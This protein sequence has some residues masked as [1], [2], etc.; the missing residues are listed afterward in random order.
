[1]AA[2]VNTYNTPATSWTMNHPWA[3]V[4]PAVIAVDTAGATWLVAPDYSID[5]QVTITFGTPVA[6]TL[7]LIGDHIGTA[8]PAPVLPAPVP[9]ACRPP[10]ENAV[11][12]GIAKPAP[13]DEYGDPAGAGDLLW[14]GT[15]AG[16]LKQSAGTVVSGGQQVTV[17]Q[18]LF[19]IR[20]L[21]GVPVIE[22][23]GARWAG[24]TVTLDD[25]RGGT[26]VRRQFTVRHM[27]HAAAGTSVDNLRLELS[28]ETSV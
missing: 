1:M 15:A 18:S 9:S 27:T 23:P 26:P 17:N 16:Y 4:R 24:S 25:M 3:G 8:G 20:D 22:T 19:W 13:V 28:D 6:G 7:T 11:L 12:V 21:A 14:A 5:G 2:L 10:S